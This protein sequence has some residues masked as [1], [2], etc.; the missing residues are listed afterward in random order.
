MGTA[1]VPDLILNRNVWFEQMGCCV[2]LVA[3]FS[4]GMMTIFPKFQVLFA[5]PAEFGHRHNFSVA[6]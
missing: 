3:A 4:V 1:D 2:A 5:L 6:G